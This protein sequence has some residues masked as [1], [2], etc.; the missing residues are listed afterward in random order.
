MFRVD[1]SG[2]V[3]SMGAA[4]NALAIGGVL[5]MGVGLH[6]PGAPATVVEASRVL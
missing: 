2:R 4:F 5:D 3:L 6:L 1:A